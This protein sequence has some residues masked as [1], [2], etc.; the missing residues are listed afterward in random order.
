MKQGLI[1]DNPVNDTNVGN[2][3]ARK[4][5]LV[6]PRDGQHRGTGQLRKV[7]DD[8]AFSDIVRLLVAD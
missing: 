6:D 2:E 7:L 3:S 4:R 8:T 1:E 5:S